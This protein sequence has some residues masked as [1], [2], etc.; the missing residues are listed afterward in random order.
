MPKLETHCHGSLSEAPQQGPWD[1]SNLNTLIFGQPG[2]TC[3]T[4][5]LLAVFAAIFFYKIPLEH[6]AYSYE[7]VVE[8][9]EYFRVVTS[10]L[11]HLDLMHIGFNLLG[12]YDFGSLERF[13]GTATYLYLSVDLVFITMGLVTLGSHILVKRFGREDLKAQLSLGYSCVLFAWIVAASVR[14]EEFCPVFFIPS[15]CFPTYTIPLLQFPVNLGPFALLL[16]TQVTFLIPPS[17]VLSTCYLPE[18]W[19]YV[20]TATR[21]PTNAP[22]SH[23][24]ESIPRSPLYFSFITF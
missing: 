15:L 14:M 1:N 12:L 24:A 4:A 13:Y 21:S 22:H 10:S 7:L 2:T 6:I 16:L 9:G 19:I 20:S 18:R 8:R 11:A 17:F 3:V 5:L 23:L